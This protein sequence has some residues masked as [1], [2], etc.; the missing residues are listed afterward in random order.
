MSL[1]RGIFLP[2]RQGGRE[3]TEVAARSV[4]ILLVA[5]L[6]MHGACSS[7]FAQTQFTPGDEAPENFPAAS[8]RDEAF[9]SCTAC[10]NFKLVAA[11][12]LSRRQWDESV[13]LMVQ[14][15]GMPV[16]DDKDKTVVLDY[17]ETAF[18]PRAPAS[19]GWQNPFL[20]Q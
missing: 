13:A 9:F 11:Q 7:A 16:L 6:L 4:A 20:K 15:H 8:G 2:P 19:G 14:K 3:F 1:E 5:F 10:H 18:P 17:L 12:G